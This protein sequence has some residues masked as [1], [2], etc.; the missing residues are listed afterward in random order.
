VLTCVG[1]QPGRYKNVRTFRLSSLTSVDGVYEI[2]Q[3]MTLSRDGLSG[4]GAGSR[5]KPLDQ[6]PT[7]AHGYVGV[8]GLTG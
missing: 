7:L 6:A 8:Y 1:W 3:G 2:I 4:A 5:V